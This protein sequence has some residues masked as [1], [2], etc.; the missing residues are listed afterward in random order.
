VAVGTIVGVTVGAIVGV[1]VA[2]ADVGVS[3]GGLPHAVSITTTMMDDNSR[4]ENRPGG[5][6]E[7]PIGR[8]G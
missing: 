6:M 2:G 5:F 1:I 7:C 8:R 3:G 4:I